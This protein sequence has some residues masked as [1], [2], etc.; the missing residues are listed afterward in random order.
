M[1][2]SSSTRVIAAVRSPSSSDQLEP[3]VKEF[4]KDRLYILKCDVNESEST[5]VRF[6]AFRKEKR[7]KADDFWSHVIQAAAKELIQSGFL[8]EGKGLDAVLANAGVLG[9]GWK[10]SSQLYRLISHPLPSPSFLTDRD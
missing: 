6:R 1:K 4:G 3:L 9:G 8:T 10:S 5:Q 2:S 7:Q